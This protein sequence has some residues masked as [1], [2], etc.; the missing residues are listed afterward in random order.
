MTFAGWSQIIILLALVTVSAWALGS[1]MAAVF[2]GKRTLLSPI[3]APL[4][5]SINRLAGVSLA[6]QNWKTYTLAMLAFNAVGFVVLYGLMRLQSFLPLNPQS[7]AAVPEALSF[8]TAMSFVTNTNW[9]AYSGESTMSHFVQMA[10]FTVHNFLSAATGIA[11]AVAFTRAFVRS[12]AT[13]IGN[14]WDDLVKS[15]IHILLPLSIIVAIAYMALGIPQTL[16]GSI[17]ATTLE[18]A[19]QII[20]Y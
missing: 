8:N 18:G 3:L 16:H 15:T 5:N 11:L 2:T 12:S 14:F 17:D 1:Y 4:E 13:T 20:S 10:G 19:K 9:Q 6:E 7:F